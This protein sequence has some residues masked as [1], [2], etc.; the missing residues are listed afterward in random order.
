M[1]TLVLLP[2]MDGTGVFFEDFAAAVR[3]EFE[4]IIVR[5]PDDPSLDYAALESVARAA[6]PCNEPFLML[7]ESFSGP[8]AISVAASNPPGL[9]GLILCVTFARNPHPLLPLVTQ[10]LKPLPAW[11]LP[12]FIQEPNIF[13]KFNSPYLRAK[14]SQVRQLVSQKTLKARLEAVAT[15]D[16]SENLSRVTV[17]TL[18]LRAKNDRVVPGASGDHIRKVLPGVEVTE[19]DAPHLMLQAVPQDALAAIRT[20]ARNQIQISN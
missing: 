8:I 19:L 13:G 9:L 15:I 3:P 5:Y 17:P 11:R 6:L 12:R 4:P 10:I 18:D 14:L 16:V 2:G 1:L 20:F 7:G